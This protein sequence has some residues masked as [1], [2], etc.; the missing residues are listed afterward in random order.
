MGRTATA[1]NSS[2]SPV[3]IDLEGRQLG[4]RERGRVD[5]EAPEVLAA[6]ARGVLLLTE[7]RTDPEPPPV[8]VPENDRLTPLGGPAAEPAADVSPA[9][10][11][12]TQKGRR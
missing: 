3:V 2:D 4:G 10:A 6:Q 9:P 12:T 11:P 7:D 1:Y 8:T 5:P